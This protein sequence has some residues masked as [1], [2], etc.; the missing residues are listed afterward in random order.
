MSLK[1]V[2]TITN[3]IKRQLKSKAFD[4]RRN[5]SIRFI[6]NILDGGVPL[7]EGQIGNIKTVSLVSY[8]GK[9]TPIVTAEPT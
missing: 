6:I 3:D 1:N 9:A 2:F 4:V 7:S 5:D 8:R